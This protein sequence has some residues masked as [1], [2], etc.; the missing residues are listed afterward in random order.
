M[1]YDESFARRVRAALVEQGDLREVK[2][3]GGLAFMVNGHMCCGVLGDELMLRVGPAQYADTLAHPHAREM[4]FTGRPMKG[5]V[6]V[7]AEGLADDAALAR[8]VGRGLAFVS[9]LPP[10]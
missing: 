3:F 5:M 2:M 8:W 10:K 1:A 7:A 6:M 4:D 9:T